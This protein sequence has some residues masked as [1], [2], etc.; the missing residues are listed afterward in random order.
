M[1]NSSN[2]RLA[3][4]GDGLSYAPKLSNGGSAFILKSGR[5]CLRT[6]ARFP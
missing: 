2:P 5:I 4:K 6:K 1:Q 3:R